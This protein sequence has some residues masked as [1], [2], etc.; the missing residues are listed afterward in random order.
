MK[1]QALRANKISLKDAGRQISKSE[2]RSQSVH[3]Q[4]R[5]IHQNLFQIPVIVL[6][7]FVTDMEKST[8]NL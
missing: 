7:K 1:T 3:Y 6:P 5:V 8:A 2:A 4:R